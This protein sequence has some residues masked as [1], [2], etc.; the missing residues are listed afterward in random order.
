MSPNTGTNDY[1]HRALALARSALGTTSP[2]PAVG[3]VL[4]RDGRVVGE[5]H[6]Q[7][8]GSAHAE[9]VALRQAGEQARGATLYV[10]LEPCCH[11]GRTPPCTEAIIAAGVHE[12]RAAV[13][14]P[15]P[16]VA[17]RGIEALRAAGIAVALGEGQAEALE[18]NEPFFY[19]V[20]TRRPFI[21]AKYAMSL[22]GKIATRTGHSRWVTGPEARRRVHDLRAAADALLVGVGT[23]LADDP[24]LTVR[25]PG[26]VPATRQPWRVVVDSTCRTPPTARV[27]S[28]AFVGRTII[29]TTARAP[30]ERV[31]AVQAAGAEALVLPSVDN[32]V[33]LHGLA[34]TLAGRGI[35][36]VLA[37]A[38]GTLTASLFA[39]GL[40]NKVYAF[41]APKVVGG[42]GAPGPVGGL[43][44]ATMDEAWALRLAAVERVGADVLLVG[45]TGKEE[46]R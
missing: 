35:I 45:Y 6:T 17:G 13:L 8:P 12:V 42:A 21:A 26:D 24:Q 11:Y 36:N 46:G 43:G 22:D 40:V 38:G 4:V 9:I 28:D 10:T 34:E 14:D 2:N 33:D 23:V 44:S 29:A 19:W 15:N 27:L 7:P 5:G 20:R 25:T 30:R 41:V 37:E 18:I 1:M 32:R 3:A 39:E 31:E 16:L